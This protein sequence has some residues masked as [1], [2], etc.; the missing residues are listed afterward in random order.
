MT[1]PDLAAMT[2]AE[3]EAYTARLLLAVEEAR[4][5]WFDPLAEPQPAPE[6]PHYEDAS[7]TPAEYLRAPFTWFGGKRRAAELVWALIGTGEDAPRCY[8]EPFAGSLAVLLARPDWGGPRIETVNDKDAALALV[9]RSIQQDPDAVAHFANWPVNEADLHARHRWIIQ[10]LKDCEAQ[11]KADP[12]F[13]DAQF[14]GW[15]LWGINCWIGQ[16]WGVERR[17]GKAQEGD[18]GD[19]HKLNLTTDGT[20]VHRRSLGGQLPYLHGDDGGRGTNRAV[21]IVGKREALGNVARGHEPRRIVMPGHMG[22]QGVHR[23]HLS[24]PATAGGQM[25]AITPTGSR[26]GVHRHAMH[27]LDGRPV[28]PIYGLTAWMRALAA[29]LRR[30]RVA[31]GDWSRVVSGAV[32]LG[33]T[34]GH[35]S[36]VD[37]AD[38]IVKMTPGLAEALGV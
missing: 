1:H 11:V 30:V 27:A 6:V 34:N 22:G 24:D 8:V 35:L 3:L 25:P 29:R 15:W 2:R 14:A 19:P 13:T 23:A 10:R 21:P 32:L 5:P 7:D 20:G 31:C 36:G 17:K 18:G 28:D 12:T 33:D 16:G 38:A 9:W 37:W 26:I 4:T